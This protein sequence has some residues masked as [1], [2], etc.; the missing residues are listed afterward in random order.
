MDLYR[1]YVKNLHSEVWSVLLVGHNVPFETTCE[2]HALKKLDFEVRQEN[3]TREL[4]KS[5][6]A[7][8][9]DADRSFRLVKVPLEV[10]QEIT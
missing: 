1:I 5:G 6:V 2:V 9:F 3:Q 4:I 8:R 7:V 10:V